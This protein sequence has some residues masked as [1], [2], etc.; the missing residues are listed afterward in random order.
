MNLCDDGHQE[1]CFEGGKCPL[2]EIV[3]EKDTQIKEL[4]SEI[5]DLKS[6]IAEAIAE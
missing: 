6:R 3:K 5:G 1:I 4:T 2:C